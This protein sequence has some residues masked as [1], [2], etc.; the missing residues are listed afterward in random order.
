M[1]SS[2]KNISK[3]AGKD[4]SPTALAR[5]LRALAASLAAD[6][7]IP[8]GLLGRID[9]ALA[10][11]ERMLATRSTPPAPA[12]DGAD[13]KDA[14]ENAGGE[15]GEDAGGEPRGGSAEEGTIRIWCDG[16][17]SPNPGE[18]GWG[19]I[20]ER[21]GVR[22]ELSGAAAEST[23]NIMEMTAAI[24]ALRRTPEGA[25][26]QVTTD[27]QYVKNGITNWI[28]GWKRKGW[29]KADGSAVLNQQYWR[30]LDDLASVRRL[31][32]AWIKGHSGHPENERCDEL[33]R[34]ARLAQS[35]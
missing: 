8:G 28:H 7:S 34:Q 18:G 26:I 2:P 20:V 35:P 24:E 19:A 10:E 11:W 27:S 13:A 3:Q 17:C 23:N 5:R 22:E 9:A 6:P 15:S 33:A 4:A 21:N 29:R 32:W 30:D 14:G 16:S 31:E 25:K 1:A 12:G